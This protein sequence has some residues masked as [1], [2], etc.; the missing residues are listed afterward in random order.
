MA[1]A[2]M[3]YRK[4]VTEDFGAGD[5]VVRP[6]IAQSSNPYAS[7][8][9]GETEQSYQQPPFNSAATSQAPPSEYNPPTY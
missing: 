9:G 3:R 2:V 1:L 7:F 5:D 4:G 6:D 8:G